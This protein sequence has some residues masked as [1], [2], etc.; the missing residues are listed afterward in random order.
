MFTPLAHPELKS[1]ETPIPGMFVFDLDIRGDNRGWFKENWQ[2]E[3]MTQLGLPDFG[4]VQ[5]NISFNSKK[6]VTRGIHAEPW[7]KFISVG[8]GSVFGAWVDLRRGESFGKVFTATLDPGK[9]IFVPAGVANAFQTLEDNTVY[10]YLVND[11]WS[12]DAKYVFLNV[13][14][15]TVNIEWPIPLEQAE[16]S[17]K[18]KNHPRL[19][20]VTP[21]KPRKILVAGAN[22]QVGTALRATFPDAEFVDREEFD[23]T[24]PK[25]YEGRNWRQYSAIINA[26]AYTAVDAAEENL[27][28]AWN[29]NASAVGLLAKTATANNLTLVHLSTDYVFSSENAPHT[30]D[31]P[32]SPKGVYAQSKAAGDIA[33]ATTPKHYILRVSWVIGEGNNFVRVMQNLA[34]KGVKPAVVGDQTGRITFADDIAAAIRHLLDKT[35]THGT[36]NLSNEGDVVSWAV[37]AKEVFALVGKD[38]N[39]VSETT[40][41]EYFADKP[42]AAP[43]PL[44][45]ELELTKIK[46][47]GFTPRNWRD[48]LKEYITKET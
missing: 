26:A 15:E 20:D 9:A 13:Q 3:K 16:L 46:A 41:T 32:F 27:A 12:P 37:I 14:D 34:A 4:P 18:D 25:A 48:A 33:A 5:N 2:R 30:E 47:T 11:H 1:S 43:R 42:N 44:K 22:G 17:E 40:T 19:K 35:P 45:S 39:D 24:D 8:F 10:T 38:R 29:A 7:D 36:Y 6:G 28:S 31:E 23:I 21:V